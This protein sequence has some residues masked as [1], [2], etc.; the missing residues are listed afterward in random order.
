MPPAIE[1]NEG[2]GTSMTADSDTSTVRPDSRTAF[3][4]VSIVWAIAREGVVPETARA[5]R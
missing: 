1:R 3:P 4:A 5:A 2:E